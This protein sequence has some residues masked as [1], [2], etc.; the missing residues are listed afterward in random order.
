MSSL[1]ACLTL[2]WPQ[3]FCKHAHGSK[4]AQ[5]WSKAEGYSLGPFH[6][7]IAAQD[8]PD[9]VARTFLWAGAN[10]PGY[11]EDTLGLGG[12]SN[13]KSAVLVSCRPRTC[14]P[15]CARSLNP[16]ACASPRLCLRLWS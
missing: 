13:R 5:A 10:W 7:D 4:E 9:I 11:Y 14:P 16:P 3:W 6:T 1:P 2:P 8:G 12:S 15:A